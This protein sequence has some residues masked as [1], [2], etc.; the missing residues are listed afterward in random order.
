M[1]LLIVPGVL[2]LRPEY[3]SIEDPVAELRKAVAE[4]T[5]WLGDGRLVTA[6]GSA[7]RTEKA[8]GHF[9]ARAETF[10]AALGAALRAGD[11]A[12]LRRLDTVLAEE[13]WADVAALV[14]IA[15]ELSEVTSVEVDYD[16]DPYGVQ[17]WVVRWECS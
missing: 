6:N 16:D 10:D 14:A 11:L 12:A 13:L 15:G 1:K 5:D 7:M 8:P 9:D 4:A 3:A 2:A 17:Y